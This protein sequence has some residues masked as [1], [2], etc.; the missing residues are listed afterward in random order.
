MRESITDNQRN[1]LTL[2][3]HEKKKDDIE[4]E[5]LS[6]SDNVDKGTPIN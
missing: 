2:V 1:A 3:P 6:S 4:E 5:I